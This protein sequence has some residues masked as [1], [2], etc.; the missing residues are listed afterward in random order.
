MM[1]RIP[2]GMLAATIGLLL[3]VPLVPTTQ[4]IPGRPAVAEASVKE[5]YSSV[6]DHTNAELTATTFVDRGDL[7]NFIGSAYLDADGA[8]AC[9]TLIAT[10]HE[11]PLIAGSV[12]A[13]VRA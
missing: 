9:A 11:C 3:L 12:P 5:L 6:R 1:T 10:G 2:R 7:L 4:V 13:W 8:G